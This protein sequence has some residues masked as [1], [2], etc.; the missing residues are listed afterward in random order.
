M[1]ALLFE[2]LIIKTS[3]RNHQERLLGLKGPSIDPNLGPNAELEGPVL[4]GIC[5]DIT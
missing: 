2:P 5:I 3:L 4:V 1:R